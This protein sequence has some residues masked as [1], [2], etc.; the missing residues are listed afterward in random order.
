MVYKIGLLGTH[1]TGKTLL[2]Y[3]VAEKLG[4][5]KD[6]DLSV[7]VIGELATVARERAIPIDQQTTLEAQAWILARQIATELEAEI[8]KYDVAICDRTVLDN[9][10]YMAN[11]I[12][13]RENYLKLVLGHCKSHPYSKLYFL[14][15]TER[16]NPKKRDA[17]PEFQKAIDQKIRLF[18]A[19]HS[20][21]YITLLHDRRSW[22]KIIV[23]Q[24][25]EDLK[26]LEKKKEQERLVGMTKWG[27]PFPSD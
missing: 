9:Y 16:L 27:K 8:Y 11:K 18:L 2:S 17:D 23:E 13:P 7:R 19:E 14:P 24:T 10:C 4:I 1:G 5:R 6:I 12:G 25:V 3:G 22:K 15:I 20:I 21:D 26:E